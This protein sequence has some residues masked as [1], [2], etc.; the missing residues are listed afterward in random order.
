MTNI[1]LPT[2]RASSTNVRGGHVHG[3][4]VRQEQ[5]PRRTSC[6]HMH[7][8]S[9]WPWG[10]TSR[11][12][13]I[14]SNVRQGPT[15]RASWASARPGITTAT[16][17]GRGDAH[18]ESIGG[19]RGITA[20][21]SSSMSI[22]DPKRRPCCSCNTLS[23]RVQFR[24]RKSSKARRRPLMRQQLQD[25]LGCFQSGPEHLQVRSSEIFSS[26]FFYEMLGFS[27]SGIPR[28]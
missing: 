6:T 8:S 23:R 9:P 10:I 28:L 25:A 13:S 15:A 27:E 5:R 1:R 26:S 21:Q 24:Q 7:T 22:S 20:P 16:M 12:N 2:A 4:S 17:S 14:I 3:N 18:G 11:S 19:P